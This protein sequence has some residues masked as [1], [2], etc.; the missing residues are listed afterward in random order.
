MNRRASHLV[1]LLGPLL[2]VAACGPSPQQNT[3]R[4]LND[5][6]QTQLAHDIAIGRAAVQP[7]PDGVRVTLLGSSMFANDVK[8]L[9]DQLPVIRADVIEGLLDPTLMRVQVA[10]TSALPANQRNTRV[11]NVEAYFAD[12]GLESV[13][14]PAN[15]AQVTA[16]AGPAGLTITVEVQ[17]P[18]PDHHI[19]YRDGLS[20]PVCE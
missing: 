6:M 3:T 7:L 10:D 2:L 8:A 19:G 4:L 13:L 14:V 1:V 12:N 9:D 16:A 17:C 18:P 20:R 15:P 11:Q 5:R